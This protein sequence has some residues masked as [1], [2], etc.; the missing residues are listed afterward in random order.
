M[1]QQIFDHY[2][3]EIQF[4]DS[5]KE[6]LFSKVPLDLKDGFFSGIV[7]EKVHNEYHIHLSSSV[8]GVVIH[9]KVFKE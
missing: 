7:W 4:I 8:V 9:Q 2:R 5:G 3:I 1:T 6:V